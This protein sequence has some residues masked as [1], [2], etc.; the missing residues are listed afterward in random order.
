[1]STPTIRAARAADVPAIVRLLADDV[2]GSGREGSPDDPVYA[3]AFA[4]IEASPD[5]ALF[6]LDDDGVIVGCAQ[7]TVV[8]GLSSRGATRV[9]VETV[10]VASERRGQG[11]GARLMQ[12]IVGMARAAGCSTVELTSNNRRLDAHRFYE[13][14]GFKK[15]HAGFKL[16]L[17]GGDAA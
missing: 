3:R 11:L 4:A 17:G 12:H 9:L 2:L 10:R 6:V 5:N 7:V 16:P 13:R 8:P 15:S 1:M 14:L